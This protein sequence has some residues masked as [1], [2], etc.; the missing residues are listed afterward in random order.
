ML[1]K[2]RKQALAVILAAVM[3]SGQQALAAELIQEKQAA[4]IF[5]DDAEI[6]SSGAGGEEE[7]TE[8]EPEENIEI[9]PEEAI[10]GNEKRSGIVCTPANGTVF[11]P[12]L[13]KEYESVWDDGDIEENPRRD[14][15]IVNNGNKPVKVNIGAMKH[16]FTMTE[17]YDVNTGYEGVFSGSG[18]L[19][20]GKYLFVRVYC[21]KSEGIFKENIKINVSNGTKLSYTIS[22]D[23]PPVAEAEDFVRVSAEELEFG[24][25]GVGYQTP[26]KAKKITVTNISKETIRLQHKGSSDAFNVSDFS[27][28]TLKPGEKAFYTVQP[29]SGLKGKIYKEQLLFRIYAKKNTQTEYAVNAAFRVYPYKL[30]AIA[31]I[32]PITGIRNG[33]EKTAEGLGLP[34]TVGLE[35]D[36]SDYTE[37]YGEIAWDVKNCAY[38]PMQTTEQKFTVNGLVKLPKTVQNE[39]N[40]DLHVSTEVQVEAYVPLKKPIIL[41]VREELNNCIDFS[42]EATDY[43]VAGY[44]VVAAKNPEQLKKGEYCFRKLDNQ[45]YGLGYL[46]FDSVEKGTYYFAMRTY[47]YRNGVKTYSEWSDSVKTVKKSR[48]PGKAVIKSVKIKGATVQVTVENCRNCDGYDG[49]LAEMEFYGKPYKSVYIVK[50]RKQTT[51]TFKNVKNGTYYVGVHGYN[52]DFAVGSR[53]PKAFGEW[54]ELKRIRVKN[55]KK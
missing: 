14:I 3:C 45:G 2:K 46:S 25:T 37:K 33:R 41:K 9:L 26:P 32:S 22:Q 24:A 27:R 53:H 42:F 13:P 50:N 21:K 17:K 34:E 36:G 15:E 35:L 55:G 10:D 5:T 31:E 47:E 54:S 44:D 16:F 38:N 11:E 39:N 12:I 19:E 6:F 20:P 8:K 48:R 52:R 28:E 43:G 1:K 30:T 18:T 29:K 51:L 7:F 40:I 49:V 4:E 23:C